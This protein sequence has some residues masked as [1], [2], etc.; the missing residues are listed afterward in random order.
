MNKSAI[1]SR[2]AR[3]LLLLQYFDIT[4]IDFLSRLQTTASPEV[5]ADCF[6]DE[7]LFS[8]A[9]HT[10]WYADITNY[11]AAS[12]IPAHFSPKER[13]LLVEKSFNFS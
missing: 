6:P 13:Q 1:S 3:W 2:L 7:H 11:L 10:L 8:I 12:K 9:T 4:V 5:I